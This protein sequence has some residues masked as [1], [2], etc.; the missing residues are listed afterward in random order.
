MTDGSH[1]K[2]G[3]VYNCTLPEQARLVKTVKALREGSKIHLG[4]DRRLDNNTL[5]SDRYRLRHRSVSH[6]LVS[7]VG[8]M[9]SQAI[10][11]T[12]RMSSASYAHVIRRY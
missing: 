9:Y 3:T 12:E 7:L 4:S 1:L 6:R 5:L 10:I 8:L 2:E 11:S